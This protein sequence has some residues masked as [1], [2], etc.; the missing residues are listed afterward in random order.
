MVRVGLVPLVGFSWLA[1]NYGRMVA[2]IELCRMVSLIVGEINSLV[3][4]RKPGM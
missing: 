4:T 2:L 1:M 3:K